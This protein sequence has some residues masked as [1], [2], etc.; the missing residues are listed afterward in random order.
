MSGADTD[1][2]SGGQDE[3]LDARSMPEQKQAGG[4]E[5]FLVLIAEDEEPIAEAIALLVGDCG[6]TPLIANNGRQ[7]LELA[8][9]RRP[10]LLITDLMMPYLDGDQLIA[11]LRGD[12][13]RDGSRPLPT[14]LL[15]AAG[16][17]RM[18]TSS[19][20]V[21]L[22]KPFNLDDLEALL[23]RFLGPPPAG[24]R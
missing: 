21:L 17:K 11:A 2:Q 3:R 5:P 23:R 20:D 15:S 8:R 24:P 18:Q 19:A 7:A 4:H 6:Y 14:I 22:P 16:L 1:A 13:S 12:A 10:A 9:A